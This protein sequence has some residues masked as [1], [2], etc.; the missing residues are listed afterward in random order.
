MKEANKKRGQ[1]DSFQKPKLSEELKAFYDRLEAH[2]LAPL[3]EVFEDLATA[4]PRPRCIPATWHYDEIRP[5]LMEAADLITP[6]QAERR[7]LILEN[8][9]LRGESCITQSLF[10]AVQLVMPGE[11]AKAHRHTASAFRF[12]LEGD[13]GGYTSLDGERTMMQPG[14]FVLTPSW[15]FHDHG[16]LGNK[17]TIWMDGLDNPFIDMMGVS[18]IEY[19]PDSTYPVTKKGEDAGT[20][21]G[22][23]LLPVEYKP[24]TMASP[25]FK[26]PYSRSR[27]VVEQL[28]KNGP[29]DAC[30]GVKMQFVNPLTGGYPMPSIAGFMQLLPPGFD[31]GLHRSTDGTVFSPTE[32]SGRSQIGNI[33]VEW[34][35]RDVFVVP[36]WHTVSH[37]SEKGAVLFSFSDRAAQKGLGL[38]REERL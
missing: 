18:F 7:V 12:M 1:P 3:W 14:D 36:P 21:Y 31:G 34:K 9:G 22:N 30:H 37:Q 4:E 26:Y 25:I 6:D 13:G 10:A 35:E 5:M 24:S 27:E 17:P 32:G 8:P 28:Y 16:N 29:V 15:T 11:I 33:T 38:W 2:N 19:W 20:R 23:N